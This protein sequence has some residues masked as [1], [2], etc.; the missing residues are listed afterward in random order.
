MLLASFIII[1]SEISRILGLISLQ[2]PLSYDRG[3]M[4]SVLD[5]F[6]LIPHFGWSWSS[7]MVLA[8]IPCYWTEVDWF[9]WTGPIVNL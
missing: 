5:K 7:T 2:A 6:P 3:V 9:F 4:V 1:L 8:L